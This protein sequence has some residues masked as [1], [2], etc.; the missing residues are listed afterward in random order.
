MTKNLYDI[1]GVDKGASQEEI[2]QAYKKKA[3]EN[4]E[5][6]GGDKETMADINRAAM[7][8]RDPERRE[9]YDATGNEDK[10]NF[11]HEFMAY[12]N[13]LF[14]RIIQENDVDSRDLIGLF[15]EHTDRLIDDGHH[16]I[17]ETKK[18]IKR[19]E[20]VLK[21]LGDNPGVFGRVVN[22]NIDNLNKSLR[23]D[24]E[25][26]K[27]F[28]RCL[29]MIKDAKYTYEEGESQWFYTFNNLQQ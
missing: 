6:K 8:L 28:E 2:K 7:V 12:V 19:L 9:R 13:N 3:K 10:D 27:F 20:K 15:R 5:D 24:A 23:N 26:I 18:Q 16:T 21:R 1:L 17:K 29:D 4:H 22:I 25:Q 14:L 11:D